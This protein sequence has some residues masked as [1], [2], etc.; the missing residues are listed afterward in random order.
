MSCID[1]A[2]FADIRDSLWISA[3]FVINVE[4]YSNRMMAS[5]KIDM[6]SGK[7]KATQKALAD[8]N[9]SKSFL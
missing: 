4:K 5:C 8:W 6:T 1:A 3:F 9:I 2:I 7:G